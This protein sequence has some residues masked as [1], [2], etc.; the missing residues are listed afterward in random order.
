ML[1]KLLIPNLLVLFFFQISIGQTFNGTGG[2]IPDDGAS[3]TCFPITVTGVGT[4]N[5]TYGLASVCLDITHTWDSDIEI[6]LQSPNG[7]VINLSV[8]NGGSGEN[9]TNTCFD[10]VSIT[11]IA[12]GSAP[13]TGNFLPDN[14][15]GVNNNGQNANG[16]WSL[17]IQDILGG[18][19][20]TLNN[21]SITFNNTPAPPPPTQPVCIGNPPA[22]NDCGASTPVCNFNGYCGNTS[23]TYTVDDWPELSTTFCGTIDNNSFVTFVAS[24]DTASFDVWVSNS[25]LGFGIQMMF[26]DGGCGSG[27]VNSYGCYNQIN[28]SVFPTT[29]SATGLTPGNTYYLMFD[30][31]AGDVCDYVIAPISGVN[32]LDVTTSAGSGSSS[33]S[34]ATICIGESIILTA[35]GG[36]GTYNWTGPG[37]SST[38]GASVTATPST[39]STYSVTSSD[40]G[41]NCPITKD[42]I[43]NVT[44]TPT[45]PTVSTPVTICQ[46][47]TANPL[48]ATGTSL[49][50]YTTAAGGPTGIATPPTPST[51]VAGNFTY[52]VSQ[53][54]TCGES[55]RVPIVVTVASGTPIPAVNNQVTYCQNSIA[56][57]LTA[58]GSS[59]LWY[60]S[61]GGGSGSAVAPVPS[62][63]TAGNTIYYVSQTASCG[64]SPRAVITVTV[65]ALPNPPAIVSPISYCLG[66]AALPLTATGSNLL[67]YTSAATGSSN[68]IAP[69][70]LTSTVGNT[71]YYV[72]QTI[73]SCEGP[74]ATINVVIN[75]T[76]AAP[77]A[78]SPVNYC[79]GTASVP[80]VA[81][82]SGLLWYNNATGGT[83]SPAAPSPSTLTSGSSNYYVSQ[84]TGCGESP[85]IPIQVTINPIPSAPVIAGDLSY[86]IGSTALPLTATGSNLSW[87]NNASGGPGTPSLIPS[88]AIAGTAAYYA[89]Q[90][91]LGCES[92]RAALNVTITGLPPAPSLTNAAFTYC[93]LSA[94]LPL[95]ATGTSLLWYNAPTGGTGSSTAPL[96]STTNTGVYSYYVSQTLSCGESP[97]AEIVVT[98]N[99]TPLAPSVASPVVYCQGITPV[100]LTATGNNLLWY[101]SSTLGTGIITAPTPSTATVGNTDYYVSSTT[102]AC[103]GPRSL[104]TITVNTTP[105]APV[106]NTPLTYCEGNATPLLIAGGTNLLWYQNA[107]GGTGSASAPRPSTL[108]TGSILYYVSQTAGIC[109][110]P[111]DF[112]EVITLAKPDLG[113]DK[114][115]TVCFGT[116]YDLTSLFNTTGLTIRWTK[117][118]QEI[119]SPSA[120]TESGIYQ[121]QATN[122]NGCSDSALF[123][124][125]I[126]PPVIANAGRDTI[127]VKGIPHQLTASGGDTYSWYPVFPLD[128]S[129][130]PFG[131]VQMANINN[132]QL[133]VVTAFNTIGCSDKD[134]VFISVYNG[135]T[136]YIPTAFSPD[137]DGLN[138]IFRAIPVGIVH[139]DWF[140]IYN[141]FGEILYST[142][143]WLKG[144]DGTYR[145]AKQP[146]G[147]YIWM[148][149]GTDRNGK[150]IERK[151]T[152]L[153]VK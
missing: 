34:S 18:F 104:I 21:W 127:A 9:Y 53:T 10:G 83:G 58:T 105:A 118:G 117:D 148:I 89:S 86:C 17:C 48:T 98:V 13:F 109:E 121:A 110:G 40:P 141:R 8:Q 100:S 50:W 124:F 96:P 68:T 45:P 101:T 146:V 76:S 74:R 115:D 150:V 153:I 16:V 22:G 3:P 32:I 12:S 120:I 2:A 78:V 70:P 133:F 144:W 134:S 52:Y 94:S 80:L 36:S 51:A 46:N 72:S 60:I 92:P 28:P 19:A 131:P 11:S 137:G 6:S 29:I 106:V 114:K 122:L 140:R 113:A 99:P 97:R 90:T 111:R 55:V 142:N 82:G 79:N 93:Q 5:N 102:G 62:T 1:K 128:P 130:S 30:G 107:I 87:Y 143:N 35:S 41:G 151:G 123:M 37:L 49:L 135:P 66:A 108:T 85:R 61:P 42:F 116:G 27:A 139:T 88:T 56:S 20:G 81:V 7:T 65:N 119:T 112:I 31:Y 69:T 57:V 33:T 14:P 24:D 71:N 129:Y 4:I 75:N 67:W 44:T 25:S 125:N 91:V 138:D 84:T 39:N 73:N 132:D 77:T 103:E 136:Y 26:Y 23:S 64:E 38:T 43:V 47:T 149:K 152:V 95:T 15:L 59:L 63:A 54:L 147:T 126:R 145:N